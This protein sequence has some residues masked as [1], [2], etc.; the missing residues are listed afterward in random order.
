MLSQVVSA[1][2]SAPKPIKHRIKLTVASSAIKSTSPTTAQ[3]SE[4]E[5]DQSSITLTLPA[6]LTS[7]LVFV[8]TDQ[9]ERVEV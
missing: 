4:G 5:N 1:T 7:R 9:V 2:M 8:D 3:T 6:G